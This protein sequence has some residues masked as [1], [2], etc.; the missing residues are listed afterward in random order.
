MCNT[1]TVN[2]TEQ[3]LVEADCGSYKMQAADRSFS[4][5][6]WAKSKKKLEPCAL[7]LQIYRLIFLSTNM[8]LGTVSRK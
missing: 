3:H 7:R 4:T 6:N 5:E 1:I 2:Q 8:I